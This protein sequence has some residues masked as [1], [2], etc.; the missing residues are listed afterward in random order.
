MRKFRSAWSASVFALALSPGLAAASD[1]DV[2]V[3]VLKRFGISVDN[4]L[5]SK[6]PCLCSGGQ[7]DAQ[8]GALMVSQ[9]GAGNAF[10]GACFVPRFDAAGGFAAAVNCVSAGGTFV[11]LSK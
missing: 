9:G 3:G 1:A 10:V 8:V 5:L 11:V 6:K 4:P 2:F 7:V